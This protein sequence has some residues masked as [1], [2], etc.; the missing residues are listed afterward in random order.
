MG[1][2][3]AI[4]ELAE[5]TSAASGLRFSFKKDESEFS[6]IPRHLQLMVYRIV[7]EQFNNILKHAKA[8]HVHVS[9]AIRK[10]N[11]LLHIND[12]GIGFDET[13]KASGIGLRNMRSRVKLYNGSI[14]ITSGSGKG[15]KLDLTIPVSAS[16]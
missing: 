2:D 12:D 4:K 11:L 15:T 7:Q 3:E 6:T 13:K 1:L 9:L 10:N 8:L 16:E 14:H 5:E